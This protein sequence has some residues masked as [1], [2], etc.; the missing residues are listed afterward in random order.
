MNKLVYLFELDS[1]RKTDKEIYK[2]QLAMYDELLGNGN[3]IVMSMNQITD[4]KTFLCMLESNEHYNVVKELLKQGYIRISRYGRIRTVSQ[5]VQNAINKNLDE[6]DDVFIF[7]ALPVK[8]NQKLLLKLMQKVLMNSDLSI[9][10]EYIYLENEDN[11]MIVD[12][13]NEFSID[14]TIKE[15][16]IDI[17]KAKDYLEFLYRFL[18]LIII[19][20]MNGDSVTPG[21]KYTETYREKSFFTIMEK[22]IDFNCNKSEDPLWN[23]TIIILSEIKRQL[24]A[25][26]LS[27]KNSRSVWI[28]KIKELDETKNKDNLYYAEL[29]V[30]LCYNYTVELSIY[31]V[32]KHYERDDDINGNSFEREFFS[33]LKYEWNDGKDKLY[34]FLQ[35]ETN[36]YS[37]YKGKYPDWEHCKRIISRRKHTEINFKD[38]KSIPLY[39]YCYKNQR[40]NEMVK[41]IWNILKVVL[42]LILD[43]II[44]YFINNITSYLQDNINPVLKSVIIFFAISALNDFISEKYNLPNILKCIRNIRISIVDL[45]KINLRKPKTYRNYNNFDNNHEEKVPEILKQTQTRTKALQKYI[46][47]YKNRPDMFKENNNMTIVK[48]IKD[49]IKEI[50]KYDTVYNKNIGVVY[51]SDYNMMVVDLIRNKEDKYST[52]ERLMPIVQKGAVVVV[53]LYKGKFILLNQFRHAIREKQLA[54]P[55]GYGEIDK[56]GEEIDAEN[57][58]IK[59][60]EEELEAEIIDKPQKLGNVIADSGIS[61]NKVM[62]YTV[63]IAAY[64]EKSG[65][66]GI[67]SIQLKTEEELIYSIKNGEINDGYT[68]AAY[69][70]YIHKTKRKSSL[71]LY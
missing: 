70:L 51:K 64:K 17:N 44:F 33:R 1:V 45:F 66:E 48:P 10:K 47:L 57:N 56:N 59:E 3:I 67:E 40:K 27:Q 42:I 71:S 29:I 32:S 30:D 62:I 28:K 68:L 63:N 16:T 69:M 20:S 58:A 34:R 49:G 15:N 11:K 23:E 43:V 50:I 37:L 31:G 52:Y 54:F 46:D 65:Y 60:I 39:E 55:R 22:I 19:A 12:L 25:N 61:A 4:S 35:E 13:F 41:D 2:G 24:I 6:S 21:I 14:G 8:S 7:S 18:E 5:Y 53:P 38:Y 36:E 9:I 26:G